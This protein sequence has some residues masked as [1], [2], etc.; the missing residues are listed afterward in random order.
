MKILVAPP[1]MLR[2]VPSQRGDK[3]PNAVIG[4]RSTNGE[5]Y[6]IG[7]CRN[8][9]NLTPGKVHPSHGVC[10]IPYGGKEVAHPHYEILIR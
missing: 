6:F 10:Y 5:P 7:R 4:G 2:W 1:G 9:G 8:Q 3:V